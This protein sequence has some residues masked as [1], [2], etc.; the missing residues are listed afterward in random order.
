MREKERETE[1]ER[2]KEMEKIVT[3]KKENT[4]RIKRERAGTA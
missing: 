3:K 2:R 1:R 4:K